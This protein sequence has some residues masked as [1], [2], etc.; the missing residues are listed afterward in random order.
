MNDKSLVCMAALI[1]ITYS[2]YMLSHVLQGSL[3]PDGII[4]SGVIGAVCLLA[5]VKY[6]TIRGQTISPSYQIEAEE[7]AQA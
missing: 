3:A 7:E 5:G 4:L 1:V 2:V 6:Q